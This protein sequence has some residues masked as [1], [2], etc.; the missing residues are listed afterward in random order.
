M[1][2]CTNYILRIVDS[3]LCDMTGK[4]IK[5]AKLKVLQVILCSGCISQTLTYTHTHSHKLF[6]SFFISF[7]PFLSLLISSFLHCFLV[8]SIE[9]GHIPPAFYP[10]VHICFPSICQR[11]TGLVIAIS[12]VQALCTFSQHWVGLLG[13]KGCCCALLTDP[14]M[15]THG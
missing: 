11:S 2:W 1:A 12:T 14:V 13:G 4:C 5:W 15:P 3:T 8:Y 10:A 6:L 9:L 7:F